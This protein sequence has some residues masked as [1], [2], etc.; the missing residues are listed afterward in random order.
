[1]AIR[2]LEKNARK[3]AVPEDGRGGH[4]E[5]RV[6]M[7]RQRKECSHLC[8]SSYDGQLGRRPTL[9]VASFNASRKQ[10]GTITWD[11]HASC[12]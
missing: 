7:T 5:G 2:L 3:H 4:G 11:V 9:A 6:L 10:E 12:F 1:M 8:C